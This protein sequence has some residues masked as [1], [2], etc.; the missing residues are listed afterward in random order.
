MAAE[1]VLI[2]TL[3]PEKASKFIFTYIENDSL[4]SYAVKIE[5]NKV[6]ITGNSPTTLTR[7]AYDYLKKGTN[8]M[9]SWSGKH[10]N[11]P[12]E[13][14]VLEMKATSPYKN[15]YYL[16]VCAF[17]YSTPYWTWERWE[18]EIDWMALHG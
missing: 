12:E 14:P 6:L 5:N 17:G 11:I 1:D 18:Q 15:R 9:V 13:L 8:S 7:G 4:D 10:L 2:R 16:N 3:G